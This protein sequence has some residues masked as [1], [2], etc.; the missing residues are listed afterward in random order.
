MCIPDLP[1]PIVKFCADVLYDW[2]MVNIACGKNAWS[3]NIPPCIISMRET[4]GQVRPVKGAK[5][6]AL[7]RLKPSVEVTIHQ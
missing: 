1:F 6:Y 5:A 2:K 4:C 3:L 7:W